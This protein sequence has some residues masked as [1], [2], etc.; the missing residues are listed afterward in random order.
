MLFYR[1]T[2]TDKCERYRSTRNHVFLWNMNAIFDKEALLILKI[3]VS[4]IFQLVTLIFDA[5]FEFLECKRKG[6]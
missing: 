5:L 6:I 4:F 2:D 1:K 3:L